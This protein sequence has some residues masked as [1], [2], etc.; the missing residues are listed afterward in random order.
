MKLTLCKYIYIP[1]Q[2]DGFA[3][4][5]STGDIHGYTFSYHYS[6]R[7]LSNSLLISGHLR[8]FGLFRSGDSNPKQDM[9]T[10]TVKYNMT[11]LFSFCILQL[12][13]ALVIKI[14]TQYPKLRDQLLTIRNPIYWIAVYM[15]VCPNVDLKWERLHTAAAHNPSFTVGT[16][17]SQAIPTVMPAV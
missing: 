8:A 16:F 9:L 2:S 13:S 10:Q 14:L 5:E 12:F 6:N 1:K 17:G 4:G 11:K 3:V 7:Y 15:C